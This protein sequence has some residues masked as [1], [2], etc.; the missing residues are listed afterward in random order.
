MTA[1]LLMSYSRLEKDYGIG[2]NNKL[3]KVMNEAAYHVEVPLSQL[4]AW[5][6][7]IK[8]KFDLQNHEARFGR[9]SNGTSTG[10]EL[11]QVAQGTNWLLFFAALSH[12]CY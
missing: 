3:L 4:R 1:G 8:T 7:A 6:K 10:K 11:A 12:I 9:N 2:D 5:G